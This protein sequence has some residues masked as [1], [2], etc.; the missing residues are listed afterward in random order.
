MAERISLQI[1]H[2]KPIMGLL[3]EDEPID[4]QYFQRVIQEMGAEKFSVMTAQSLQE[5]R[6]FLDQVAFDVLICDLNLPDSQGLETFNIL[7]S[8][9]PDT[10][11]VVFTGD[12][13]EASGV[14]AVRLGAQDY[15]V[16]GQA[17]G[18]TIIRAIKYAIERHRLLYDERSFHKI[19]ESNVECI[20]ILDRDY[21]V[22]FANKSAET[23]FAR[24]AEELLTNL[25]KLPIRFQGPNEVHIT[26]WEREPLIA[27]VHA[28]E[29][30]WKGIPATMYTLRDITKHRRIQNALHRQVQELQALHAIAMSGAEL[31]NEDAL[32]DKAMS[33][34][35]S[36]FQLGY[37]GVMLLDEKEGVLRGHSSYRL[38]GR[39]MKFPKI[40]LHKGI[41]GR[42]AR[43]GKVQRVNDVSQDPDYLAG[44]SRTRSELC[45]PIKL[46]DT[47]LGVINVESPEVHFYT[48]EDE[49]LLETLASQLATAMSKIRLNTALQE[50]ARFTTLLNDITRA[51]ISQLDSQDILQTI[52]DRLGELFAADACYFTLWD[53]GQQTPIP[54]AAYGPLREKYPS[55]PKWPGHRTLTRSVLEAERPLA[56]PNIHQSP[57]VDPQI[58][59]TY[60]PAHSMLVV[61]LIADNQKLGSV[62]IGFDVERE[63]SHTEVLR[64]KQAA[65]QIALA[66]AK[67]RLLEET[68]QR[69]NELETLMQIS[70]ALR[71]SQKLEEM[72]ESTLKILG[73]ARN[74]SSSIA[75]FEPETNDY[76]TRVWYPPNPGLRP[77]HQSLHQGITGYVVTTGQAYITANLAQDPITKMLPEEFGYLQQV[78]ANISLPLRTN[79]MTVGVLHLGLHDVGREFTEREVHLLTAVADLAG[80]A[81]Y[82]AIVMETLEQRV[83]ERTRDLAQANEQ[84]KDL[85]RLRVKF[86]SDMSHELRTPVTNFRL[87][88]DLLE[89]GKAEKQG[90]YIGVLRYETR[91][92]TQ[93][94]EESLNLSR[95]D[96]AKEKIQFGPVD[97]NDLV[98]EI[99]A[100]YLQMADSAA[101]ELSFEPEENLPFV[102]G[103]RGQLSQVVSKL[104]D[105]AIIY[106]AAGSIRV[107]THRGPNGR[108]VGFEIEDTGM[109]IADKDKPHVFERFYRGERMGQS[110]IPGSGLGLAIVK[111]I[112]AIHQ[113]EIELESEINVG[114]T[115]RIWLPVV[116][117]ESK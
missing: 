6:G 97:L 111:E 103:E 23:L 13:D 1:T 39:T 50:D 95:L 65:D 105:N 33:I 20:L 115:F 88:L 47:I 99:V 59:D 92:L 44:A 89:R 31:T 94:I 30:N 34:I 17:N 35:E 43:T 86:V 93:L 96:L 36:Y 16:K 116:A 71:S 41:V 38:Q 84:L 69:A 24:P 11:I 80:S 32:I 77:L 10:P 7:Q 104:L 108:F 82:R 68:R 63:F 46:G 27:E 81:I 91:R 100:S 57:Y 19:I 4:I 60:A 40:P 9:S 109:G 42:A 12:I 90:Y 8:L 107:A 2:P 53:E 26:L 28:N 45:A 70:A 64:A 76:V 37:L 58:A 98:L 62:K 52:A 79:D 102:L 18:R 67:G 14:E 61:P 22:I 87:Y 5:A 48:P 75:L 72:L 73:L 29:I 101:L 56:I 117:T 83:E 78:Q 54:V 114:S 66:V 112:I 3:I 85:D 25:Y 15:L 113:G 21:D 110:N 51:A 74:A 49:R 106:T 55:F